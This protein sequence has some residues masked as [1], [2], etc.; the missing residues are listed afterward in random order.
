MSNLVEFGIDHVAAGLGRLRDHVIEK[1]EGSYVYT[2]CL[3]L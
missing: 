1:G 3:S 2:V